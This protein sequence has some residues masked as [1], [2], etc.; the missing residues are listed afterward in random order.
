VRFLA[1]RVP[2]EL[3]VYT[4]TPTHNFSGP[5]RH[6]LAAFRE[7]TRL[8]TLR[9]AHY[10][11]F[12]LMETDTYPLV[13][14]WA[15]R[16]A[17]VAA[18]Q[19]ARPGNGTDGGGDV[20][21]R[22]A[23]SER[24]KPWV[25][26]GLS[27][28]LSAADAG[29]IPE[30]IN[31]N[32]L[33]TLS[34][35]TFYEHLQA[36]MRARMHTW[37]F[38]VMIGYWLR[39]AHPG[40]LAPSE[41][42]VSISSFQR[43]HSC[44]ELVGEIVRAAAEDRAGR[45]GMETV[46]RVGREASEGTDFAGGQAAEDSAG[47][48]GAE[49]RVGEEGGEGYNRAG[50][51]G[52]EGID[53]GVGAGGRDSYGGASD[54][55]AVRIPAHP[56]ALLLHTGNIEKMPDATVHPAMRRLGAALQDIFVPRGAT[57]CAALLTGEHSALP[58]QLRRRYAG[59]A[60]WRAPLKAV[61]GG[62]AATRG[63][64][65]ALLWTPQLRLRRGGIGGA[66]RA[67]GGQDAAGWAPVGCGALRATARGEAGVM[68][69]AAIG[70]AITGDAARGDSISGDATRGDVT[71]RGAAT[72]ASAREGSAMGSLASHIPPVPARFVERHS[73]EDLL[74]LGLGAS[75]R[76]GL[77]SGGD[78]RGGSKD[79]FSSQAGAAV[80]EECS[81]VLV[82][83]LQAPEMLVWDAYLSHRFPKLADAIRLSDPG[84]L[85]DDSFDGSERAHLAEAA[86]AAIAALEAEA[87]RE[88][89]NEKNG[90][91]SPSQ[92]AERAA[93]VASLGSNPVVCA[94]SGKAGSRAAALAVPVSRAAARAVPDASRHSLLLGGASD[95]NKSVGGHDDA[96]DLAASAGGPEAEAKACDWV[97]I[98][99]LRDAITVLR[100][101][102]LVLPMGDDA[103][104]SL[105]TVGTYFGGS[106]PSHVP[107]AN[108]HAGLLLVNR[109]GSALGVSV[110]PPEWLRIA[111]LGSGASA[112]GH[113][114]AATRLSSGAAGGVL[115]TTGGSMLLD[116]ALYNE[117]LR[118]A[119]EQRRSIVWSEPAAGDMCSVAEAAAS[120]R[121]APTPEPLELGE[122][123]SFDFEGDGSRVF[124]VVLPPPHTRSL[125]L[126]LK[127]KNAVGASDISV[128][129][130]VSHVTAAPSFSDHEFR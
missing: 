70:G 95:A 101:R 36:E 88:A 30:H 11:H 59:L 43:S 82:V 103:V 105:H 118:L 117:A 29:L 98:D 109:T 17:M 81:A 15:H 100:E 54:G 85:L 19:P 104:S 122:K 44:C 47:R 12:Q 34:P 126:L 37:A 9:L 52:A 16:L 108:A 4:I 40:K 72:A 106:V 68:G 61:S 112:A 128:N 119:A 80:E 7:L 97:T 27:I 66:V 102:A 120:A 6:F 48:Q 14:G 53:V 63:A 75:M 87:M 93:W 111:V 28:C 24:F 107:S 58:S 57:P 116:H 114:S 69:D 86:K 99:S 130:L 91:L 42:V 21:G 39:S 32:A 23:V 10:S 51:D 90:R 64:P 77:A 113:L 84:L 65:T 50:K 56:H 1:A 35:S 71:R 25:R 55:W 46:D 125:V 92:L 78:S 2:L 5:N 38:D 26:G 129:L 33:Y 115:G 60:P 67:R 41:H 123:L 79:R 31:G 76:D 96:S 20:T 121:E 49:A 18:H 127:A 94:L 45:E 89:Q 73:L 22:G 124:E 110:S 13:P 3:D 8:H 74:D 62:C 83:A